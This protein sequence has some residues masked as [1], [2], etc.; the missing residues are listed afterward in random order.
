MCKFTKVLV[1]ESANCQKFLKGKVVS[2][3]RGL[4]SVY[5]MIDIFVA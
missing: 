3:I 4:S 1:L 5:I 2:F